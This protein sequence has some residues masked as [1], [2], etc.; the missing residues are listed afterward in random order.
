MVMIKNRIELLALNSKG[1]GKEILADTNDS[2]VVE[3]K[4]LEGFLSDLNSKVFPV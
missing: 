2:V 4:E 3:V 1:K